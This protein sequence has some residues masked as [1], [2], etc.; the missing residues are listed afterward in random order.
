M[1]FC[2]LKRIF[3]HIIPLSSVHMIHFRPTAKK[4]FFG[5]IVALFFCFGNT[6]AQDGKALFNANCAS[7][8]A[9]HKKLT[10]P[11]LAGVEER[12][13]DQKKLYAWIRNS[14]AFL[15]TGDKYA[16]DLYLAYNKTAMNSFTNLTDG[17]IGAMLKYIRETPPPAPPGGGG[18]TGTATSNSGS[19]SPLLFGILTLILAIVALILLQVNSN[20]RKLSDDKEGVRSGSLKRLPA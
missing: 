12:W 14:A 2:G 1:Y 19:S 11:A 18:A 16:N 8:H 15:A 3:F 4:A 9:V 5:L 17:E 10:G 13:P 7:C 6:K 20:L